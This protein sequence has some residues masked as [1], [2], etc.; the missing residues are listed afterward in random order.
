MNYWTAIDTHYT[1][2]LT[3]IDDV[4]I[5]VSGDDFKS[6]EM[7][8]VMDG[9]EISHTT[10]WNDGRFVLSTDSLEL[11]CSPIE[12]SFTGDRNEAILIDLQE[13]HH[14]KYNGPWDKIYVV[15]LYKIYDT[16][17]SP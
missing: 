15:F 13:L 9:T 11:Y 5:E 1:I 7:P 12:F 17:K 3:A 16:M 8:L 2:T 14:Q 6:F 10:N 4:T